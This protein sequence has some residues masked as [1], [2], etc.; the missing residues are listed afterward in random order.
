[1]SNVEPV[2]QRY[3]VTIDARGVLSDQSREFRTCRLAF[4]Y[5]YGRP[6]ANCESALFDRCID[7][8]TETGDI[9]AALRTIATDE[10]FCE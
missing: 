8:Y 5:L 9:R 6:E 1:M 7:A 2:P 10:S 3:R 4:Q